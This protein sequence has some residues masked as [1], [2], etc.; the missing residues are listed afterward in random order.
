MRNSLYLISLSVAMISCGSQKAVPKVV[1]KPKPV[2][3]TVNAANLT[4]PKVEIKHE[5]QNDFFKE[6]IADITKNDNTISYGSIVSANP[7]GYKV[8]KTCLLYTS[9]CV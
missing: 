7:I 4:K 6:N 5:G 3:S 8:D 1:N 9:R 2:N